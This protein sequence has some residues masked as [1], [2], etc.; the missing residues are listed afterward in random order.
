MRTITLN[1]NLFLVTC[2][3]TYNYPF[4]P[5]GPGPQGLPAG[6]PA[7]HGHAQPVR[8]RRR[9]DVQRAGQGEGHHPE[10]REGRRRAC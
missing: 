4:Q 2:T 9:E 6:H 1:C 5:Q 8:Q 10:D 3:Y 7:D